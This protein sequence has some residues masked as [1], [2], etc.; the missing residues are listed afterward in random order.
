MSR[1]APIGGCAAGLALLVGL[2]FGPAIAG[3]QFAFRDAAH[4]IY[5][6]Y[7]KV[8]SEWN[9]GRWPL[10]EAEENGGMPLLG[11]PTAAVLYPGKLIYRLLPYPLAARVY[12]IAHSLLAFAGMVAF[13]RSLGIGA[14]GAAVAGIGYAFGGPILF[15]YCTLVYLVSAAW[16]P[17]AFRALDAWVRRGHRGAIAGLA[18]VLAMQVL[19]GD[20]QMAYLE[21][22]CGLAYAILLGRDRSEP[23]LGWRTAGIAVAAMVVLSLWIGATIF[24]ASYLPR[25]RPK[26]V[27]IPMFGWNRWLPA[28]VCGLWAA[29]GI[30]V[31][32]G[33]RGGKTEAQ[34]LGRQ[35]AGLVA[36][37]ALAAALAAAQLLP[38][39]EYIRHSDRMSEIG[40]SDTYYFSLEPYRVVEMAFPYFFGS[41]DRGNRF[42]LNLIPPTRSHRIW[43][44]S[45]YLGGTTCVLALVGLGGRRAPAWRAWVA[46]I[47]GV[48]LLLSMGEFA[49]PIWVTRN[50]A[51]TTDSLGSHDPPESGAIRSDGYLR[52][53]DGSLYHLFSTAC[54]GFQGF[55][56]PSKLLTLTVLAIAV[57]AGSGWDRIEAGEARAG[58]RWAGV[59][60]LLGLAGAALV[61]LGRA[62]LLAFFATERGAG[63]W[64]PLDPYGAF[65]DLFGSTMHAAAAAGAVL[66]TLL[67]SRRWPNLARAFLL[68]AA[69][70][71]VGLA[72]RRLVLTTD[73]ED[74]DRIPRVVAIIAEAEKAGGTGGPFRVHRMPYWSPDRWKETS[75]PRRFAE[76]LRWERDTL[77]PKYGLSHG[78]SYTLTQGVAELVDYE[79]FFAPKTT[80]ATADVAR[81]LGQGKPGERVVYYPRRAFDLWNTRY[82]LLP[83]FMTWSDFARGVAAFL[84]DAEPIYPRP[85][86]FD[87]PDGAK[88]REAWLRDED[89]QIYRNR[90]AFPRAW[91]VHE[92]RVVPSIDP[93]DGA[94]I[95]G[96]MD[97]M[98]YQADPLWFDPAR[99]SLDPHRVAW[100]EHEHPSA[101]DPFRPGGTPGI[102]ETVTVRQAS[103]QRVELEAILDR[104]GLVILADV[105]YPGWTLTVDD[106]PASVLRANRMMRGAAVPSGRHRLVY[107]YRPRSFLVGGAVSIAGLLGLVAC[108]AWA[109]RG[110]RRPA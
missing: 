95:A 81:A 50:F 90:A 100:I 84:P 96:L 88:R 35:L 12:V 32:L 34:S 41:I 61:Q 99:V 78:L 42:W 30:R 25:V 3:R 79:R 49:G 63:M 94:R 10:W 37:A 92:A 5:P 107:E 57:L 8:E 7:E 62:R 15:Q 33:W 53:G 29:A 93:R 54:P 70:A 44:P 85:G 26:S 104:P 69:S 55:R 2:C 19:A 48:S 58:M 89:V 17:W 20:P 60:L 103:P 51:S 75:S 4:Y 1:L 105:Y 56:Y 52:D 97:E 64:G 68:L 80:R 101:L 38:A 9:E 39:V 108:G 13:A 27:P 18:F 82:F 24:L 40:S 21:G 31:L 67:A 83:G 23:R 86:S 87:G 22:L 47:A 110:A 6:L 76:I 98:L 102:G 28:V 36:A 59:F 43:A 72:N 11:N 14:T 109:A 74:F 65:A 66:V 16:A 106:K 71:D 46:G 91:V 73:Q 45:L 77:L